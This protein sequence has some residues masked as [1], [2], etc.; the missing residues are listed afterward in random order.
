MRIREYEGGTNDDGKVFFAVWLGCVSGEHR[1]VGLG[2]GRVKDSSDGT[3]AQA[4][5][6]RI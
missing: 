2:T 1:L 4:L 6:V 5:K 3:L